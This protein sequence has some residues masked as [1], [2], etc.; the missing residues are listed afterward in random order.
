MSLALEL[1][2]AEIVQGRVHPASVV[3]EQPLDHCVLSLPVGFELLSMQPFHLQRTEQRLRAGVVPAVASSTHGSSYSVAGEKLRVA[4]AGVLAAPVRVEDQIFAGQALPP[5]HFQCAAGQRRCDRLAHGPAHDAAAEQ[6]EH[7]GQVQPAFAGGDVGHVA[8]PDG[9]RR[10]YRKVA[11][12]QV[13]RDRQRMVAVGGD[14][15]KT[16]L[17]TRSQTVLPHRTLHPQLAHANA[18]R[19]QLPPHARPAIRS[20][21]LGEHRA[22]LDQQRHFAQI[23]AGQDLL[24]PRPML[25]VSRHAHT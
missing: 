21:R 12:Q 7:H 13:G 2:W 18:L 11:R 3:P 24:P 25:A 6:I 4:A 9:V 5:C 1:S 20:A 17:A 23:T 15:A 10:G 8:G 14:D 16:A 19:L 22:D